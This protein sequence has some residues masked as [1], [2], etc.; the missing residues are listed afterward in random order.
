MINDCKLDVRIYRYMN[1]KTRQ[2][3]I[4]EPVLFLNMF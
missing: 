2:V 1:M 4:K 3:L